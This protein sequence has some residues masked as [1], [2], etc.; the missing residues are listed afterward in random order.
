MNALARREAIWNT[1][2]QRSKVS[3]KELSAKYDVSISTIRRDV[4]VLS[5]DHPI[6]TVRGRYGGGVALAYGAVTSRGILTEQQIDCLLRVSQE[7]GPE[8]GAILRGIIQCLT[9]TDG[10]GSRA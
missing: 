4:E 2:R 7:V 6:V 8:D 5:M 10:T 9:S 3:M 1:I